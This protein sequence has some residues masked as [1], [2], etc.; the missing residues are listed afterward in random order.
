LYPILI[1]ARDTGLR[2]GALLSLTWSAVG[3]RAEGEDLVVGDFLRIPKGNRYKK[4]PKVIAL[5]DRLRVELQALWEKS[6]RDPQ[7]KIFGGIRDVKRSYNKA[8]SLAGVEDLHFH[9]WKHGFATDM[10]EAGVEER[11]SMRAAGHT[12]PETHAIY[13][14]VDERLALHIAER[15]NDLHR[16][17]EEGS[18]VNDTVTA[19]I[20]IK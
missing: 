7:A 5:T 13:T 2:K 6:T 20:Y 11:L 19:N 17:R 8:C 1:A 4:R 18:E 15:L 14:N 12:N 3:F 9:D 16:S 10:M